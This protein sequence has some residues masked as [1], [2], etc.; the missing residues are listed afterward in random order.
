LARAPS[1]LSPATE[2]GADPAATV[3]APAYAAFNG[4]RF[5]DFLDCLAADVKWITLDT[6]LRPRA[7]MGRDA[8]ASFLADILDPLELLQCE[9]RDFVVRGAQVVV[10]VLMRGRRRDADVEASYPFVHHWTVR[11]GRIARFRLYFDL[12]RALEAAGC[13]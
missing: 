6:R 9:P 8:V 13:R 12:A 11:D 1:D 2:R 5:D 10:P 3:V 7:L 4:G